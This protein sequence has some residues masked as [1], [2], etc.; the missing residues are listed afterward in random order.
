MKKDLF[1]FPFLFILSLAG[2][3]LNGDLW[4]MANDEGG[5]N[6][7]PPAVRCTIPADGSSAAD[8]DTPV[9]ITFDTR[10][11]PDSVNPGTVMLFLDDGAWLNPITVALSLQDDGS[12]VLLTPKDDLVAG[13]YVV[14]VTTGVRNYD[15]VALQE[16]V[17]FTFTVAVH[18]EE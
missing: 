8:A 2:C 5:I 17:W 6:A 7:T 15:G 9:S 13:S 16:N 10:L 12:G 3:E 4:T 1:R 14:A 18:E 11:R